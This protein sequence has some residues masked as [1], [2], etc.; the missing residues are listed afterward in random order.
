MKQVHVIDSHTGGEPTRLV[1]KGFP[2][3]AG[4]TLAEQRD[5]LREH[6]DDWRRACLLEPRGNDVLVGALYCPPVSP[7][8][9]CGVIFFNN[10]GYLNMCGHGTIGLVASLQHLGLIGPGEHQIDTPV[11]QVSATLHDDGAVTVRNVPAYRYRQRVPVDVPGFGQV[12][13]DIAWGGNWF[14]LVAEH[15]QDIRLGNVERLTTFTWAIL[16]ALQAQGIHGEDG[17]LIDHVELFAADE[18]ADSRNFVMCPGKAYDRSPCGTGTSAKL[19]CLAADGKL[20]AG[21]PWVQASITGS[22][23]EG[24]FE[25]EGERIRPSITGRAYMTA[26]S[27][28]LIDEQDPFAWGI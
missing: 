23:F 12:H 21:Q 27:T 14:F 10:S 25:W 3:L 17:G 20:A 2:P 13:G 28:L 11:G 19:A 4:S 24:R 26:D 16:K 18:T 5:Y 15:D 1:M 8:A 9:T 7:G 22:Q 6:H